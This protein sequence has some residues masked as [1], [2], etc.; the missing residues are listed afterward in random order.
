MKMGPRLKDRDPASAVDQDCRYASRNK[1][2]DERWNSLRPKWHVSRLGDLTQTLVVA[3]ELHHSIVFTKAVLR[4]NPFLVGG[5]KCRELFQTF[6][7]HRAWRNWRI[8]T[9]VPH[10]DEV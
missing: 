8:H 1:N 3:S 10:A 7:W 9:S 5:F 2:Q 6:N 4:D